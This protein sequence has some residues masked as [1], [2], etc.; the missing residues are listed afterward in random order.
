MLGSDGT[1]IYRLYYKTVKN[2]SVFVYQ[3]LV[4]ISVR[5]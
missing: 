2:A 4:L 1:L 5:Y 3:K